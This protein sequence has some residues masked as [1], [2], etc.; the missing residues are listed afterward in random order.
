M[1]VYPNFIALELKTTE[2]SL[3]F[4]KEEFETNNKKTT[5]NIKKHQII[6]LKSAS[7]HKGVIAGLLINFRKT[8]KTYFAH[9]NDFI[10]LTEHISKKSV[11]EMDVSSVG[12]LIPQRQLRVNWRYDVQFLI[13]KVGD[14]RGR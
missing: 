11:N 14:T 9:I 1:Y 2:S 7:E 5:F 4:W 6:G 13:D 3:T 8:N 10:R 12:L